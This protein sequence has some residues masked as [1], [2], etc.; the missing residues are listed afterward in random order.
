MA[1]EKRRRWRRQTGM[2]KFERTSAWPYVSEWA[3]KR[4]TDAPLTRRGRL[5]WRITIGL[6]I[7]A[8]V[9]LLAVSAR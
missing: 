2:A 6:L 9:L 5:L 1:D 8:G 4:G 3:F 7:V